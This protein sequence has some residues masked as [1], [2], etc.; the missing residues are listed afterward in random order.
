MSTLL[1]NTGAHF[2]NRQYHTFTHVLTTEYAI[3]TIYT[4]T[5]AFSAELN[6]FQVNKVDKENDEPTSTSTQ[7]VPNKLTAACNALVQLS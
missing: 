4:Y 3:P 6:G 1:Q 5:I 7:L 2:W